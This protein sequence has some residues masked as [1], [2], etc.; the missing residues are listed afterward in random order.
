MDLP[1]LK[2][3]RVILLLR[4][5]HPDRLSIVLDGVPTPWPKCPDEVRP[6]YDADFNIDI[7]SGYGLEWCKTVLGIEPEV[8]DAR[9]SKTSGVEKLT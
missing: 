3:K 9:R 2:A 4:N 6:A 8:I 1:A 7:A 5:G